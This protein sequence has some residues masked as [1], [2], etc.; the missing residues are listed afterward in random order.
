MAISPVIRNGAAP[1]LGGGLLD[2]RV[3]LLA[4]DL[5]Q[6]MAPIVQLDD[7]I[8]K[9][10]SA[11]SLLAILHH[12]A[13]AVVLDPCPDCWMRAQK[14]GG[15]SFSIRIEHRG[16]QVTSLHLMEVLAGMEIHEAR[17]PG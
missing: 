1:S 9:V 3:S 16:I 11:N 15:L 13:E 17:R 14:V 7:E 5:D 10:L 2:G 12:Q 4:L 6:Q 8:G